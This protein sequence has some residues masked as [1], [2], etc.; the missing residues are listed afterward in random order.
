[1]KGE[2]DCSRSWAPCGRK[3]RQE[4]LE[5]TQRLSMRSPDPT[6]LEI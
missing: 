1:M 3:G 6:T 4:A 5:K 2:P